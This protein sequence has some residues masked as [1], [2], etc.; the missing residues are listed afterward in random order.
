MPLKSM[1]VTK[2]E[3]EKENA[4]DSDQ[5]YPYGLGLSLDNDTL[6]KLGIKDLPELGEVMTLV[7]KVEVVS[8]SE[9][10]SKD[11]E[12]HKNVGLQ[13]TDM[14]LLPEK[15]AVDLKKLYDNDEG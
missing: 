5:E 15:K 7:A 4:I 8:L 14:E 10:S 9:N 3:G 1:R 13:I 11:N 12:D 6:A 2:K